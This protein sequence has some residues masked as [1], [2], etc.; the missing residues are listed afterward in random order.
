MGFDHQSVINTLDQAETRP[1]LV[2]E[3]GE[4]LAKPPSTTPPLDGSVGNVG[5]I[6]MGGS[7]PSP[8]V[9]LPAAIVTHHSSLGGGVESPLNFISKNGILQPRVVPTSASSPMNT[10]SAT[11]RM[12]KVLSVNP[13]Q[14]QLQLAPTAISREFTGS[15]A[16]TTEERSETVIPL[17]ATTKALESF[18]VAMRSMDLTPK[19]LDVTTRVSRVSNIAQPTIAQSSIAEIQLSV[20]ELKQ[21]FASLRSQVNADILEAVEAEKKERRREM[22]ELAA[23]LNTT[24]AEVRAQTAV[25]SERVS[26]GTTTEPERLESLVKNLLRPE[27]DAR[28]DLAA[29]L[30]AERAGRIQDLDNERDTR[31]REMDDLR[32]SVQM[33]SERL[34]GSDVLAEELTHERQA[35]EQGD[36][37]LAIALEEVA[38]RTMEH[39]NSL[40]S[41]IQP[42]PVCEQ[43]PLKVWILGASGLRDADWVPG[44]GVS[45][46]YCICELQGK[47]ESAKIQTQVIQNDC[48]PTWNYE[49]ALPDYEFGDD[50]VFKVYDKDTG[51]SDDFLGTLTLPNDFFHPHG[52]EGELP[53][54]DA[55]K[56][57]TATLKLRIAATVPEEIQRC[58]GK[59]Q[60]LDPQIESLVSHIL[61]RELDCLAELHRDMEEQR[62]TIARDMEDLRAAVQQ[63]SGDLYSREGHE[64][65]LASCQETVEEMRR[66][67]EAESG[68][69][70][71]HLEELRMIVHQ[72]VQQLSESHGGHQRGLVEHQAAVEN[73]FSDHAAGFQEIVE[74]VRRDMETESGIRARDLEELRA[75]ILQIS[76]DLSSC[77]ESLGVHVRSVAVHQE[78]LDSRFSDIS[79]LIQADTTTAVTE[80]RKAMSFWVQ[81]IGAS[82]LR[83]ADWAPGHG[84]SDPYCRCRLNDKVVK[85][86][87]AVKNDLNPTWNDEKFQI[88]YVEG[89]SLVF[90]VFDYD[91]GK[92]DDFLGSLTLPR[93]KVLPHGFQG[94]TQFELLEDDGRT[95]A[96]FLKLRIW[97]VVAEQQDQQE[98]VDVRESVEQLWCRYEELSVVKDEFQILR[99]DLSKVTDQQTAVSLHMRG[100]E[101]LRD[102]VDV[103]WAERTTTG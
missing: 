3:G 96:G 101:E 103:I 41:S 51:K 55:G 81:I 102:Q 52:F 58:T 20:D 91:F 92:S 12:A 39:C 50:L 98:T 46:P 13:A 85:E 64:S 82:G 15:A 62:G 26:S 22:G 77:R 56:G 65:G 93:E 59:D 1:S 71:R 48:N 36:E 5:T 25:F 37:E 18:D 84:V 40:A 31:I 8:A 90:T 4:L 28:A 11:V 2:E 7:M 69:R 83:N 34:V 33:L 80:E 76:E 49:A 72:S 45:D 6:Y 10:G 9:N 57:I 79:S 86:T 74:D 73:R 75:N 47:P 63:I 89:A 66:D 99:D 54:E 78:T 95:S 44:S 32:Y 87:K 88:D 42:S 19:S 94:E 100:F 29:S 17:N 21:A 35:R 27:R 68:I 43:T 30:D 23:Y 61:R 67:M 53:L 97:P 24:V 70:A 16:V 60:G 14:G 38:S